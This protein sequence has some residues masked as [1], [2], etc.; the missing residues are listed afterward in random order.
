[1]DTVLAIDV[2][3]TNIK[4]AVFDRNLNIL[5]SRIIR[6]P[7]RD[8]TGK[9]V[10]TT[11]QQ[12]AQELKQSFNLQSLGLAVPGTLDEPR[13]I[14]RWAGNLD[15]RNVPIVSMIEDEVHL[16]VAFKHDVRAGALAELRNGAMKG[17]RDGVF[18][19]I[20]TGIACAIVLDGEIRSADGFAGEIGHVR[21]KS[22]RNCVCGQK[23]CFEATSSTLAIS[24]EYELRS[25]QKLSTDEIVNSI[26]H[27]SIARDVFN[28][29]IEGVVDAVEILAT[30]IAPEVV[31]L[32]GG[33]SMSGDTL[34]NL[35]EDG[36]NK[37]LTFQRKPAIALAA[38]GIQSGM[39]GC[40]IIAWE[41]LNG[42]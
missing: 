32:G 28:E 39:Y 20:G 2:G 1:M 22:N 42:E 30:L 24:K 9:S 4:S 3:G 25:G 13:G 37:R 26:Q 16:P 31:V 38:Y 12:L 19:P 6:T 10:V 33:F 5:D 17:F 36:L 11:I 35:F 18:L 7:D 27:D 41:K 29:A 8:N 34:I 14:V 15:W 23:G 21:V 40:G